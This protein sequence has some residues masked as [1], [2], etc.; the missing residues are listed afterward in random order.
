[1]PIEADTYLN[2][3]LWCPSPV[4]LTELAV[5]SE[6]LATFFQYLYDICGSLPR[7]SPYR[8]RVMVGPP[9]TDHLSVPEDD[10]CQLCDGQD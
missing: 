7:L 8:M 10:N 9:P 4:F 6:L 2:P 5:L 1:M 3:G